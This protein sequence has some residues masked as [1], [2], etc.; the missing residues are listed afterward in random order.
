[1]KE[2]IGVRRAEI[3]SETEYINSAIREM[4]EETA[5]AFNDFYRHIEEWR[6][7][8]GAILDML[9]VRGIEQ[10]VIDN[11]ISHTP[12]LVLPTLPQI[13]PTDEGSATKKRKAIILKSTS[14]LLRIR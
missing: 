2:E 3:T 7:Y 14:S 11:I 1:V 8:R 9:R 6:T 10:D 5:N 13:I 12:Q 4:N